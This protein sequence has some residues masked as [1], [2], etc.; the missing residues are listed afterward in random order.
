MYRVR[1][2]L[3]PKPIKGDWNGSG[4]HTNF[5]TKSMRNENGLK[6]IKDAMKKAL[7]RSKEQDFSVLHQGRSESRGSPTEYGDN[8]Y[9]DVFEDWINVRDCIQIGKE[10]HRY[11]NPQLLYHY[12]KDTNILINQLKENGFV[13]H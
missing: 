6:H 13:L 9:D 12:T 10:Q 4:C 1:I 11:S 5:S 8:E 2:T 3:E 7:S